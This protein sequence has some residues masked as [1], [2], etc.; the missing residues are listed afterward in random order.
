MNATRRTSSLCA[1]VV[2][3]LYALIGIVFALPANHSQAWR[4][5]A[6]VVS[7]LAYTIHVAYECFWSRNS[8]LSAA[9]HVA[10]GAALG[11]FGLAAAGLIRALLAATTAQHQRLMLVALVAWPVITGVPALLVGLVLSFL[12]RILSPKV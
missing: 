6:W 1:V 11:G 7:G 8:S 5:A 4:I 9:V 10:F 3:V 2:G 12:C